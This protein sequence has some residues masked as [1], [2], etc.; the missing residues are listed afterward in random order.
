MKKKAKS[1]IVIWISNLLITLSQALNSIVLFGNPNET[2][3]A[4]AWRGRTSSKAWK[5]TVKVIDA[6]YFWEEDHCLN[7]HLADV[8]F[9]KK[10]LQQ[11]I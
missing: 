7:S 3:S 5:T 2:F 11:S 10:V 9:A 4:R 6:L 8:A 1:F